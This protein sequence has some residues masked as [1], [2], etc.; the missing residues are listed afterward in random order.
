MGETGVDG[1]CWLPVIRVRACSCLGEGVSED[2]GHG[3]HEAEHDILAVERVAEVER[4]GRCQEGV[5]A[6]AAKSSRPCAADTT[7]TA[8]SGANGIGCVRSTISARR[9]AT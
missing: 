8:R 4:R 3:V 2:I 7:S 5:R 6:L 1:R 9:A